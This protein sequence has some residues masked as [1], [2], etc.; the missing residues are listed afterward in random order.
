LLAVC[1][2]HLVKQVELAGAQERFGV[3]PLPRVTNERLQADPKVVLPSRPALFEVVWVKRL[4]LAA[5]GSAP[6]Q[7]PR[8]FAA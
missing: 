3:R 2:L 6:W 4:H 8:A 5:L 1:A 7:I